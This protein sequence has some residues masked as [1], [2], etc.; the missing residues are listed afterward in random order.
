[1]TKKLKFYDHHGVEEYYIYDPEDNE[2][3]GLER[4][5]GELTVIE[6][7]THWVSP[8]L[9]IRFELTAETLRVYYPDGRK[10]LSTVELAEQAEQEKQRANLAEAENHRLRALLAE[11]GIE[12]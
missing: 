6:E 2:L 11:A 1:M 4:Q 8:R 12:A 5:N 3:T 9:G 10:F 7:M